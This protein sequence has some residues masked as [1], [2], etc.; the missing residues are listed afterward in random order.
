M[1]TRRCLCG[2]TASFFKHPDVDDIFDHLIRQDLISDLSYGFE[3]GGVRWAVSCDLEPFADAHAGEIA[4]AESG[5]RTGDGFALRIEQLGFW[6]D[7]YDDRGHWYP[8][9]D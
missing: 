5:E 6:H 8:V 1:A 9:C 7:F 3:R 4:S 2:W